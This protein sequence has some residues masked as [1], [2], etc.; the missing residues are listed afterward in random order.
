VWSPSGDRLVAADMLLV[1]E[2]WLVRLVRTDLDTGEQWDI[3]G[4]DDLVRDTAPDWSPQ[5]GWIAF[6][7]QHFDQERWTP[8]RQ[9]WLTRP[10]GSEAYELWSEPMADLFSAKWRPDGGAIAYVAS[11]LSSSAQPLP[12]VS[13]WVF[14]LTTRRAAQVAATGVAPEWLP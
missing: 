10:D 3:S 1:D 4:P 2:A 7:R 13:V 14:D 9:I 5:G 6:S 8:G 11:D 12:E